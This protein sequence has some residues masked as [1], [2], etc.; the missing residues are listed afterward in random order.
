MPDI[1]LYDSKTNSTRTSLDQRSDGP[2]DDETVQANYRKWDR[3]LY[4]NLSLSQSSVRLVGILPGS[5]EDEISVSMDVHLLKEVAMQYEAL[6]YVWGPPEPA[7]DIFVNGVKVPVNPNLY[8]A[9]ISLRRRDSARLIWIDAICL[10]QKS[11]G[12]K[13]K[14]VLKMS[15]IYS[16]AKVVVIFLGTTK[17]TIPTSIESFIKFLNRNDGGQAANCYAKLGMRGLDGICREN[18]TDVL[19]V[20]KGFIEACLQPWWGRIWTLQEFYLA[21]EEPIW[22]WGSAHASNADLKRDFGLLMNLSW[23]LVAGNHENERVLSDLTTKID[24][25]IGSFKTDLER[26]SALISRRRKTNGYDTPRRLYRELTAS[27]S[28]PRDFVYGLRSIFDPIFGRVFVPDYHIGTELLFASLA[29][30][31][32]QFEC[33]GDVLW[34]Y[35]SRYATGQGR[36][37]SWLPDFTKHIITHE[38]DIQPLDQVSVEGLEPK[39]AVRNHRL[40]ARGYVLDKIYAHRHIDKI[41]HQKIF[42]E[43]WQFDHCMNNNHECH[44]LFEKGP[45]TEDPWLKVFLEMYG[46]YYAKWTHFNSAFRGALL[47][48]TIKAEEEDKLPRQIAECV[49]CWD[50]LQWYALRNGVPGL[51]EGLGHD[52]DGQPGCLEN[53][54]SPRMEMV[55]RQAFASFFIGACIFDWGHLSVWLQRFPNAK[56]WASWNNSYWLK[57]QSSLSSDSETH[58]KVIADAYESYSSDINSA[59]MRI[60]WCYSFYYTFL[61][62]VIL[63]DCDHHDSL[64]SMIL[65]LQQAGNKLRVVY[66][67]TTT[68]QFEKLSSTIPVIATRMTHFNT[69]VELFRGRY[70]LWTDGGFRGITCPGVETCCDKKSIVAI[71]D[72]MSFPVIVRDYNQETGE[73]WLAGCAVIRGADMLHG[74]TEKATLPP[75]YERGRKDTFQFR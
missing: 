17:P 10:N 60:S 4:L 69:V 40:Q 65:R 23:E 11:D 66:F 7:K 6:S 43:L 50:L 5:Q 38:L 71:V 29:I 28:N 22:Y 31:L 34:W 36:F 64:A 37:P 56:Q 33:W 1:G 47:Q 16:L 32:I 67:S 72:G 27:A 19:C 25:P 49:P 13:S 74:D 35:P 68:T 3:E 18:L 14:E 61:A 75:D 44:A 12:E 41:D 21:E 73:G 51:L 30:F 62:Y 42:E 63:L 54:F 53:I 55:F 58:K 8:D 70:L 52:M 57:I 45:S 15:E 20:C 9:L 48:S 46:S 2:S 59:V 24:K 39:L 26:I